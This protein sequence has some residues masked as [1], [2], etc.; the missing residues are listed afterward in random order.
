MQN[1]VLLR[2]SESTSGAPQRSWSSGTD[3]KNIL[4][5]MKSAWECYKMMPV[6]W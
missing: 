2:Y 1:D 4:K 3:Y 5:T 6:S